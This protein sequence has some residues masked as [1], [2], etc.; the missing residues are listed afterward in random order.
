MLLNW[1]SFSIT[2]AWNWI[3]KVSMWSFR[4]ILEA[5]RW[6][7]SIFYITLLSVLFVGWMFNMNKYYKSNKDKGLID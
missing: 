2:G 5:F 3:G 1:Y 7:P 4:H 6:A